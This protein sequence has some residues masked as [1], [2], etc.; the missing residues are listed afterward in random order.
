MAAAREGKAVADSGCPR[1]GR[2]ARA[3]AALALALAA[4]T[5]PLAVAG[6]AQAD[7]GG[8]TPILCADANGQGY[9]NQLQASFDCVWNNGDGTYTGVFGYNNPTNFVLEAP[10]GATNEFTPGAANQ[11]Q[12]TLFPPGQVVSAFTVTWNGAPVTWQLVDSSVVASSA[13]TRCSSNPVPALGSL[14]V[15]GLALIATVPVLLVVMRRRHHAIE[16][17]VSSEQR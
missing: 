6:P 10:V 9:C 17:A 11:G 2:L 8:G 14:G 5:L 16:I 3:V 7:P 15:A 12:P 1:A 4:V 13:G